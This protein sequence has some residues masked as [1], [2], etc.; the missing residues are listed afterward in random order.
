[1]KEAQQHTHSRIAELY[2]CFSNFPD[3]MSSS[4]EDDDYEYVSGGEGSC[5]GDSDHQGET[6]T[7]SL[8]Q[9]TFQTLRQVSY[10]VI[11]E[12]KLDAKKKM[13]V[14]EV[15]SVLSITQCEASL[16]L[17]AYKWNKDLVISEWFVDKVKCCGKAGLVD[18]SLGKAMPLDK[19]PCVLCGALPPPPTTQ[20][21]TAATTSNSTAHKPTTK[22]SKPKRKTNVFCDKLFLVQDIIWGQNKT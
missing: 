10:D 15:S 18:E 9:S 8:R 17:L 4:E 14:D 2:L 5:D 21:T 22:K 20:P 16:M 12:D 11:D 13:L 19:C 3:K 1:M 6:K 7:T